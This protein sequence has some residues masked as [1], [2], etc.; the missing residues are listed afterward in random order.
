MGRRGGRNEEGIG[1][2]DIGEV[3]VDCNIGV[4]GKVALDSEAFERWEMVVCGKGVD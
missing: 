2:G 1:I 4:V 3:W